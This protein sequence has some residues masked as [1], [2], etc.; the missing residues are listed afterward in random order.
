M[1]SQ[2]FHK[3]E[4]DMPEGMSQNLFLFPILNEVCGGLIDLL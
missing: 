1:M 3:P 2:K 4:K